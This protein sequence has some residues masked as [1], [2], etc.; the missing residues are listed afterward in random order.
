LIIC[1][2][3]IE[4]VMLILGCGTAA[5]VVVVPVA[6][7][8][9]VLVPAFGAVNCCANADDGDRTTIPISAAA[10]AVT[11]GIIIF[12]FTFVMSFAIFR[13]AILVITIVYPRHVP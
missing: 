12:L 1:G 4:P 6:A 3:L 13:I 10:I 8:V 5:V 9:P 11:A 2:R 7:F